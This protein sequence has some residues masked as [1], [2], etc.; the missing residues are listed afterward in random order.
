M[1]AS[2]T[3]EKVSARRAFYGRVINFISLLR[4]IAAALLGSLPDRPTGRGQPARKLPGLFMRPER[5]PL[6]S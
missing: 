3:T 2:C 5:T 1:P 4:A 6:A